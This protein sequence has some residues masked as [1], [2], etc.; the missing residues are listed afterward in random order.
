MVEPI[1]SH[2]K[3]RLNTK[4]ENDNYSI[5]KILLNVLFEEIAVVLAKNQVC[6]AYVINTSYRMP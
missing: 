1:T 2:A 3:L 4:P 6:S 5:P